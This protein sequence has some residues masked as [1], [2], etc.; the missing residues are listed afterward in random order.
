MRGKSGFAVYIRIVSAMMVLLVITSTAAYSRTKVVERSQPFPNAPIDLTDLRSQKQPLIFGEAFEGGAGWLKDLSFSVKNSSRKKIVFISLAV[1]FTEIKIPSIFRH[2]IFL[3]RPTN[4]N[5]CKSLSTI[6]LK[7]GET[8][9]VPLSREYEQFRE[10]V[11]KYYGA[12]AVSTLT[13]VLGQV[14]FDDGTM[15]DLGENYRPDTEQVGR[16]VRVE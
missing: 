10:T 15:W 4:T 5:C 1:D 16:W 6:S 8:L 12:D 11:E 2:N 14:H 13:I 7:P 3:G 9:S